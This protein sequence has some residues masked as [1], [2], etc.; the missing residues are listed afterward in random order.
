MSGKW[1][2][3]L[4]NADI[5]MMCHARKNGKALLKVYYFGQQSGVVRKILQRNPLE[6][7]EFYDKGIDED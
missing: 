3:R 2:D 5:D 6:D 4:T 7:E 1:R